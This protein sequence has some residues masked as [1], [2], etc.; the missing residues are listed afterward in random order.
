MAFPPSPSE[1]ADLEKARAQQSLT[2]GDPLLRAI[3]ILGKVTYQSLTETRNYCNA[4]REQII[5]LGGTPPPTLTN[6]TWQQVIGVW[7]TLIGNETDPEA[8]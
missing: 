6:R 2:G 5:S 1:L 4:L 7:R 3:R 8:P